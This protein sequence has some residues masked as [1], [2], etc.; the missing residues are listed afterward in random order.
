M[1]S[2][3]KVDHETKEALEHNRWY[4][5]GWTQETPSWFSLKRWFSPHPHLELR[6]GLVGCIGRPPA[7]AKDASKKFM[8]TLAKLAA[9]HKSEVIRA[10]DMTIAFSGNIPEYNYLKKDYGGKSEADCFLHMIRSQSSL[11]KGIE[12]IFS[13]CNYGYLACALAKSNKLLLFADDEGAEGA[14]DL[15][16]IDMRSTVGLIFFC[17]HAELWR[18]AVFSCPAFKSFVPENQVIIEF[19]KRQVWSFDF[20]S[21]APSITKCHTCSINNP[22][23]AIYCWQDGTLLRTGWEIRKFKVNKYFA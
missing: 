1:E 15:H 6:E 13:R 20:N 19:P 12:E 22:P 17:P 7:Y 8:N 9:G 5:L 21:D 14:V 23:D 3:T 11:S 16:V 2:V 18:D 10:S 4:N